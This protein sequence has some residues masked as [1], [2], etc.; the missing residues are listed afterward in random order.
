MK[1]IRH[2]LLFW[3]MTLWAGAFSLSAQKVTEPL[4]LG[5]TFRLESEILQQERGINLY[6]PPEYNENDTLRYPVLYLLDGS[7]NEDFVHVVGLVQFLNMYQLLPPMIVVGIANT[8]RKR[9]FTYPTTIEKDKKDFP[10]TGGSAAFIAFI[11]KELQ[12]H[13]AA[14]YRTNGIKALAG[15]SLGGLVA[16]EILLKKTQLFQH[17]FIVSPSLWWDN[18]SLLNYLNQKN[19]PSDFTT[20]KSVFVA[21]GKEGRVM[22]A[23]AKKLYQSLQKMKIASLD[24]AFLPQE[25]HATVLHQALY[26]GLRIW[27]SKQAKK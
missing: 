18:Q 26:R 20:V 17:Y 16:T 25:N 15:Q 11:E 14:Q 6:L 10:T 21:V 3:A 7:F 9:D 23:D 24:F 1:K 12:P 19:K 27:G 4:I 2:S 8:D 13:I 5:Q 22:E